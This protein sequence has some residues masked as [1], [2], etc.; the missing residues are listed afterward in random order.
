MGA[1][2]NQTV[3][4][5]NSKDTHIHTN[6]PKYTNLAKTNEGN[7]IFDPVRLRDVIM[8][9]NN[10]SEQINKNSTDFTSVDLEEK[11]IIN[12]LSQDF[13]DNCIA[14]DFEPYFNELDEFLKIRENEDLLQKIE[15]IVSSLNR[16][17]FK[18]RSNY[19][20][21]EEVLEDIE[22]TLIDSQYKQLKGME[23]TVNLFL[24]YLYSNCMIGKKTDGEKKC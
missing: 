5:H 21:F 10:I 17:I 3:I 14:T 20:S 22:N 2:G 23:K 11:N 6:E 8:A 7:I 19:D 13:Y 9:V 4:V 1:S 18:N 16:K 12:G 24:Y 15:N